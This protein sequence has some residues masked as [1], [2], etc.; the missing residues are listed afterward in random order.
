MREN[1]WEVQF[2]DQMTYRIA[3]PELD[4]ELKLADLY[5]GVTFDPEPDVVEEAEPEYGGN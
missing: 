1:R 2:Y 4:Y 5:E 3:L